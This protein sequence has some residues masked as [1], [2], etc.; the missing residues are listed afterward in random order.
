VLAR[1]DEHVVDRVERPD[2][3]AGQV[4]GLLHR[5]Q[6]R[7]RRPWRPHSPLAPRSRSRNGWSVTTTVPASL[8]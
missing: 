8:T 3:P 7:A 1:R 2:P 4:G 5:H 6:P